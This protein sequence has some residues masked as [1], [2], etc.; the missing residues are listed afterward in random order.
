MLKEI[1]QYDIRYAS[2]AGSFSTTIVLGGLDELTHERLVRI[3]NDAQDILVDEVII[4]IPNEELTINNLQD[5]EKIIDKVGKKVR[6]FI[7]DDFTTLESSSLF[8][9]LKKKAEIKRI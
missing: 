3:Q 1:K 2:Q 6:L 8:K 9:N 7:E 5:A 4:I